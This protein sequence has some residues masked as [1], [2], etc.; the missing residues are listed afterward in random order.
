MPQADEV[1]QAKAI[2]SI[3][4]YV[5][6]CAYFFVLAG[7]WQHTDDGSVRD[8]LAWARRGW[9]RV[10]QLA[11]ALSP[12]VKPLVIAQSP[13]QVASYGATGLPFNTWLESPVGLG[14]FTV[15]ADRDTRENLSAARLSRRA[16][17][18][19]GARRG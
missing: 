10:E 13:T 7:A 4:S 16:A 1:G 15:D 19:S 14:D 18:G 6:D 5:S 9:C 17:Q 11:N 3:A 8:R 12:R 2:A